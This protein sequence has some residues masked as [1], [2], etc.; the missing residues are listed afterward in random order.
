MVHP[1][2]E[3][4][5][6]L[7][8]EM[9]TVTRDRYF[10]AV[11]KAEDRG[12]M[13]ETHVGRNV[14]DLVYKPFLDTLTAWMEEKKAGKAGRRP[15]AVRM[16]DDFGDTETLAFVFIKHLINNTLMFQIRDKAKIARMTRVALACT[17]AIHD[18]HRMR[19]FADNRKALLKRI[20]QDFQQ[21]DLPRRRRRELMVKQFHTQQLEWQAEGWSQNE[22]L[23]L[24][25][26]LIDLFRQSTGMIEEH[27]QYEGKKTVNCV[28]FTPEAVSILQDKMEKAADLFTVFYPMVVPPKP[29]SNDALVGGGYYSENVQPYR[30]VKG[31]KIKYLSELENRD[32]SKVLDPINALQDTGWRVNPVMLEVLDFVYSNNLN[33]KGLPPADPVAIPDAPYNIEEDEDVAAEYRKE[34]YMVHDANRRAISK[35]ISVLRTISLARKFSQHEAIYFPYDVDS[36]GRAYPKP[37]FLNPQGSDYVKGLLEFSEGKAI[38]TPEHQG[39][40]AIAIANAWGQDKLPLADRVKWVEDN[41]VMLQEIALDP[42]RDLRWLKADEPFMAL[43]GALEWRGMIEAEEDGRY[44]VS[45]MPIHFD[46]TCSGLQH[47]SALLLDAEGGFH[48][49]LTGCDERQD[50]YGAV[51]KKAEAAIRLETDTCD[52]ARIALEIGITRSLCKRP[53][54]IV[55]YAGTFSSCMEYVNDYYRELQED[56]QSLPLSTQEIRKQLTPY[57]AKHVW[58][59]IAS[60]VIAAR[61]AMDWITHT[62]RLASK[63]VE[64]P[65]QWTTPDGFVVQQAKYEETRLKVNTYLDGG[66]RIQSIILKDTPNLDTRQMSQSLSPNYIHSLDACH[67]RGAIRRAME[68]GGMS[69]A[70][71]HDS[72]G[73]HAADMAVFVEHCIK[74]AF[75]E[76]YESRDNLAL[77]KDEITINI[78]GDQRE[79]IRDMPASGTLD[80]QDVMNSQFFFS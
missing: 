30:F 28:T 43:R 7:E 8:E 56:G 25:I 26:V 23:N 75:V 57:V 27:V 37:A 62:A 24:G 61:E 66:R 48:V 41:E 17:Q 47:F 74:P 1:K 79:D 40:L 44:F 3:D 16:I 68:V 38:E 70:M 54:M 29:W 60:T 12:E 51:A 13:A 69:F 14:F 59:A 80:I 20:V 2:M 10:K 52:I 32:M 36:R 9:R 78:T 42:L 35:R 55:P 45:H 22:R 49:N 67:M 77:F 39:Y 64:T 53:V 73:V 34:C 71:I 18:E 19:Y 63:G 76:M 46:A 58:A 72:F 50:I 4:Q 5:L 31:A 15:K 11:E 6:L 65:I 21:R 33:V